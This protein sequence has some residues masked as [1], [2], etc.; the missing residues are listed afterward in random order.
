M[1]SAQKGLNDPR[2]PKLQGIMAAKRKPIDEFEPSAYENRVEVLELIM[3]PI[4]E[5][6][7][8]VGEG[9]EAVSEVPAPLNIS[10]VYASPATASP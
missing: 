5:A 8:I 7:K 10:S 9:S 2:Y 1:I 4:K 6:G 3:P